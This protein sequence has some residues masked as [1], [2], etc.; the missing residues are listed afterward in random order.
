MPQNRNDDYIYHILKRAII[1]ILII[2]GIMFLGFKEPKRY[3]LGYIFGAIINILSFLLLNNTLKKA[4]L[5]EPSKASNYVT[6]NYILRYFIYFIVLVISAVAGYLSF[7]TTI[8]G[9]FTIKIVIL[10]KAI[11]DTIKGRIQKFKNK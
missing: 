2:M 7:F 3:V 9:L 6:A 10:S 4:V 5:M 1:F 8:L 11:C